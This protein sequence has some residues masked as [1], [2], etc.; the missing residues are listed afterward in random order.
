MWKLLFNIFIIVLILLVSKV[1]AL[2]GVYLPGCFLYFN[3]ANYLSS[4]IIIW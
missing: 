2:K 4:K 3:K 1:Y